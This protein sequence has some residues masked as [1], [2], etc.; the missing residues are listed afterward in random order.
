MSSNRLLETMVAA[1]DPQ[2]YDM[3]V[4]VEQQRAV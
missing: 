1:V 3:R 4:D 2:V